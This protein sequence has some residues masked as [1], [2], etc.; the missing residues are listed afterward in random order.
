MDPDT[1]T[2]ILDLARQIAHGPTDDECAK[3]GLPIYSHDEQIDDSEDLARRVLALHEKGDLS[4]DATIDNC[5]PD[6]DEIRVTI[7]DWL[8]DVYGRTS[9]A[10]PTC[11]SKIDGAGPNLSSWLGEASETQKV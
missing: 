8:V 1:L 7:G 3:R 4:P 6:T 2:S 5:Y 10:K 9:R 11:P